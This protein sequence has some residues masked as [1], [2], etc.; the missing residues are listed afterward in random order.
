MSKLDDGPDA[1]TI[2]TNR[3]WSYRIRNY[4][5]TPYWFPLSVILPALPLFS[6]P[7]SSLLLLLFVN[8]RP[9]N[10]Q[11]FEQH[12]RDVVFPYSDLLSLS[13]SLVGII[14]HHYHNHHHYLWTNDPVLF[15]I[16]KKGRW[17]HKKDRMNQIKLS[18]STNFRP[19]Y[20]RKVKQS[21]FFR[22][23][24]F[25]PSSSFISTS[26]RKNGSTIWIRTHSSIPLVYNLSQRE[27]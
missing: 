13:W 14:N 10:S 22:L 6:P 26:S 12:W 21:L 11:A 24:P 7:P 9:S 3:W 19:S 27:L 23:S 2:Q 18:S 5:R 17:P 15:F 25:Q 16:R 20:R 1:T 4:C 8:D